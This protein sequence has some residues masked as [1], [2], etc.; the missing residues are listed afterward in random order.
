MPSGNN[1][2]K[3]LIFERATNLAVLR[4][5]K[6]GQE[7]VDHIIQDE[8]PYTLS[9]NDLYLVKDGDEVVTLFC[10]QKD[11]HCLFLSDSAKESMQ[12]G[13]KPKPESARVDGEEFWERF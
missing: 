13:S 9:T 8:L 3:D 11:T 6:C 2:L 1:P 4:C 10:L 7:E 12:K 5:F